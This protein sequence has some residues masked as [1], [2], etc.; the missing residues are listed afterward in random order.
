MA[1]FGRQVGSGENASWHD[2][3]GTASALIAT[4]LK[5]RKP[6][7]TGGGEGANKATG[8][9]AA[10]T[11]V[12]SHMSVEISTAAI[13]TTA[14]MLGRRLER[15][16]GKSNN[17][18]VG[19]VAAMGRGAGAEPARNAASCW[20]LRVV[21]SFGRPA[22]ENNLGAL[23]GEFRAASVR[24]HSLRSQQLGRRPLGGGATQRA[25]EAFLGC[26]VVSPLE[27]EPSLSANALDNC[28]DGPNRSVERACMHVGE[29]IP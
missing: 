10:A 26:I 8:V 21:S 27:G 25:L 1:N 2:D 14:S 17:L 7:S 24:S 29:C 28:R 5:N 23:A 12:G 9:Y 3:P 18:S 15:G 19:V 11:A 20:R 16:D 4:Q 6:H 13:V 22:D